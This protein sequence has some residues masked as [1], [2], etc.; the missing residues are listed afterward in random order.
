MP[1]HPSSLDVTF[2]SFRGQ[3]PD[4][5]PLPY[6]PDATHQSLRV[7]ADRLARQVETLHRRSGRSVAIVAQSAGTF[8]A[9]AYLHGHPHA[10]VDTL[11]LL[12]PLVRPARVHYPRRTG[13][14][15]SG[16]AGR[17]AC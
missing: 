7:L 16:W 8:V 2:F 13:A 5:A 12:S 10:Y 3:Y 9:R 17:C 14:G 1:G 11:V 6:G 4:G 15:G